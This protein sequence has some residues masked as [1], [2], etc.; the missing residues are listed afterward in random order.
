MIKLIFIM[1]SFFSFLNADDSL[2]LKQQNALYVQNM[3][4]I[5]EKIAEKFEE[6]ILSEFKI[7]TLTDLITDDYLGSNFSL[8]NKMGLEISFENTSELK[9]KYAVTKKV[10][11][12]VTQL[13]NRDLYRNRTSVYYDSDTI[14]NSYIQINFQS[15]VAKNIFNILKTNIIEKNCVSTLENKYCNN[16]LKTI[17]WYNS[18]SRWIEY[19]KEEFE[20]GNITV[21]DTTTLYDSKLDSLAIGSYIFVQNG[22]KYIKL[23]D[24]QILK[25][26]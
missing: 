21:K 25:A 8:R 14:S 26:D 11:P 2:A 19:N 17:R 13:Y 18:S 4:S 1:I 9:I 10:E 22:A 6:Y 3:I 24:N 15:K 12:Y 23:I 16:N 5:E 20:N 7:P